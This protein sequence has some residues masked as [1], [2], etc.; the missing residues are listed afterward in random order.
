MDKR[1]YLKVVYVQNV[2][3]DDDE[4]D[5]LNGACE[6]SKYQ[7]KSFC[8][9]KVEINGYRRDRISKRS[10]SVTV[11]V[12]VFGSAANGDLYRFL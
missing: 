11:S 12:S 7:D 10:V 8:I 4:T 1:T 5:K 2:R 9:K 3:I 6:A